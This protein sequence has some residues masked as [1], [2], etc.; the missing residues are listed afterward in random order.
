MWMAAPNYSNDIQSRVRNMEKEF[1]DN[2]NELDQRL[3]KFNTCIGWQKAYQVV[4]IP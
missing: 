3:T 4:M 1:E 2:L